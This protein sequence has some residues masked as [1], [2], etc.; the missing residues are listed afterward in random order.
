MK[1]FV[2][3]I[4]IMLIPFVGF[5][6]LYVESNGVLKIEENTEC[7]VSNH[8]LNEGKISNKGSL[9]VFGNITNNG[10]YNESGK[11]ILDGNTQII[12]MQNDTIQQLLI[13]GSGNKEIASDL[14]ISEYLNLLNN[15]LIP[16]ENAKLILLENAETSDGSISSYIQGTLYANGDGNKYFPVGLPNVFMPAEMHNIEGENIILSICP[17]EFTITPQISNNLNK[18]LS[19][20]YWEQTLVSGSLE[21]AII[22]LAIPPE[23]SDFYIADSVVVAY[24]NIIE[25][26]YES[27]GMNDTVESRIPELYTSSLDTANKKF[28]TLG[29]FRD[30]SLDLL[31]IPNALS[32][33][34][35]NP[36]EQA[37]KIYG[38]SF[39]NEDFSFT[40]T[41][42]WGNVV[43]SSNSLNEME[44][45]G[46]D[47]TNSKTGKR[48][49]NEQYL[50]YIDAVT[51]SGK[52]YK[53]AG[54]IWI[55]D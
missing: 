24:S 50:Y 6:Q 7:F 1:K 47:G 34:S 17:K 28:Y 48:E 23:D 49:M 13:T 38:K 51:I 35:P 14:N 21:N 29:I 5:T 39:K 2:L 37:V 44:K 12:D 43:F 54:A 42:K 33:N 40:V 31:Y 4:V 32:R 16:A 41:N 11:I 26:P 9:T 20:R 52:P 15:L 8:I 45:Y 55:L 18:V 25:G 30:S 19:T 3:H 46:W 10:Q 22:S 36:E 53:K 27:S